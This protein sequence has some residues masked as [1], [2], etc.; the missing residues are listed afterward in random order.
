MILLLAAALGAGVG[1]ARRYADLR[2]PR[3]RPIGYNVWAF[4]GL[5]R[6]PVE[7][8]LRPLSAGLLELGVDPNAVLAV[9]KHESNFKPDAA[10]WQMVDGK[11]RLVAA[12]LLQWIADTARRYGTTTAQILQMSAAEQVP[13]ILLYWRDMAKTFPSQRGR[14]TPEQALRATFYPASVGKAGGYVI[15]DKNAKPADDSEAAKKKA[16]YSRLIYQQN[17][18]LDRNKDDKVTASDVDDDVKRVYLAAKQR[19]PILI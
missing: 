12:G 4:E 17:A 14:W 18:G 1:A 8:V 6:L 19:P 5:E 9:L 3:S 11:R 2:R 7:T 13:L 15:G 16:R 10:N